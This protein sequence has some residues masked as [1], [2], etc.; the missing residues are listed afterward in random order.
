M[1]V[2]VTIDYHYLSLL[3]VDGPH[4][5]VMKKRSVFLEELG[6]LKRS[7]FARF[8][9]SFYYWYGYFSIVFSLS[10]YICVDNI[11]LI[12]VLIGKIYS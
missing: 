8:L 1:F 10:F 4:Q 6:N 5:F 2:F 7:I 12:T 9:L 11:L 3:T